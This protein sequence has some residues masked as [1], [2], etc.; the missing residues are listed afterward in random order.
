MTVLDVGQGDAILLEPGNGRPVL[1]D[2]G[3]PDA[4]VAAGLAERGIDALAALVIT[5]PDPTTPAE[6]RTCS[7]HC[8][9]ATC[10]SPE[11]TR[12]S[13]VQ[14]GRRRWSS[15]GSRRARSCAQGACACEV[16]WPPPAMLRAGA[17]G[18]EP[19]ALSLVMLARWHGFRMLLAGD[20]EAELAPVDPGDVDV[21]KVAHH[22]SEDAG[23][24][25]L[26]AEATPELAV[27]SVGD[28]NP[29][30]HPS[31]ATLETLDEAGVDV[32]RTDTD[33]ELSISVVERGWSA[34]GR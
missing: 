28:D 27:I 33:G 17:G 30:G 32:L 9:S 13:G 19:N 10:S 29:Y 31:A 25:A 5:H 3:P 12:R 24:A 22:G 15:I 7:V 8:R 18:A 26:L 21:L 4:E 23:L 16:L 11:R 1:V 20:A 6:R 2:A 14:R 34:E